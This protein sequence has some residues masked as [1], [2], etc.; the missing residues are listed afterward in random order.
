M[1]KA[2]RIILIV[3]LAA[4]CL[5]AFGGGISKVIGGI[6]PGGGG[7]VIAGDAT[8]EPFTTKANR[9]PSKLRIKYYDKSV[10]EQPGI[11]GWLTPDFGDVT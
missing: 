4:V 2:G 9:E 8:S 11:Y 7:V 1:K 6:S 3:L 5:S 10:D